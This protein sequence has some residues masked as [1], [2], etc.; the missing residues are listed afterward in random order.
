MVVTAVIPASPLHEGLL[1]VIQQSIPPRLMAGTSIHILHIGDNHIESPNLY[2]N[3]ARMFAS[4][5]WILMYPGDFGKPLSQKISES[6]SREKRDA[7]IYIFA[8]NSDGYPFPALSPLLLQS[9]RDFWCTERHFSVGI[10]RV[11]DW[12]ECLWQVSLETTGNIDLV[13]VPVETAGKEEVVAAEVGVV[14]SQGI[15]LTACCR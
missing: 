1:K 7:G 8:A 9:K 11:S 12:H 13:D 2:L 4:T 6:I 14:F 5:D 10:S 3:L 15:L